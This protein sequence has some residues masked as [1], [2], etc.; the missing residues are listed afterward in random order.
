VRPCA[1]NARGKVSRRGAHPCHGH[2]ARR[3]M[4]IG[5]TWHV[6]ELLL[7][8]ADSRGRSTSCTTSPAC[9]PAVSMMRERRA[10]QHQRVRHRPHRHTWHTTRSRRSCAVR[11]SDGCANQA[12][13]VVGLLSR[14]RRRDD[15]ET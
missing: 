5:G 14:A 8:L 11:A 3:T 13:R 4:G 2:G 12:I 1:R 6:L 9:S 15:V 10:Q 7:L